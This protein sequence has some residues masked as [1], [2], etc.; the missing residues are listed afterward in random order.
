MTHARM[1]LAWKHLLQG[2]VVAA[3]SLLLVLAAVEAWLR[4]TGIDARL[5][6]RG[7]AFNAADPPAHRVSQDPFLHYELKPNSRNLLRFADRPEYTVTID[8]HGARFPTHPL[9]KQ[10]G[11]F[12]ILGFG[13]S[14][15][16]G[17]TVNDEDTIAAALERRLNQQALPGVHF[18]VWNFGTSMYTLG[19][20][21]HLALGKM[22]TLDPDMLL[23]QHHNRGRRGWLIPEDGLP[24]SMPI[25]TV[26]ADPYFWHEQYLPPHHLLEGIHPGLMKYVASYRSAVAILRPPPLM[27]EPEFGERL[28]AGKAKLLYDEAGK[29]GVRLFFFSMPAGHGFSGRET[30]FR[31]LPEA[32]YI[33]LFRSGREP[34]FYEMHPPAVFLDQFAAILLEELNAR[35][36]L[37]TAATADK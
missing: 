22:R 31:D 9:D 12:R 33:D 25:A 8:E 4:V 16:Y 3:I 24:S 15:L 35:R 2:C 1:R 34:Q 19:Q 5:L 26:R 37:P 21:T 17:A 23:V 36:A 6:I 28:S 30:I 32:R 14:T 10:P 27:N 18:E 13:G 11:T 7:L 29:L 20:A